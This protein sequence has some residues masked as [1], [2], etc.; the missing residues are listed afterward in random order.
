LDT[1]FADHPL[2]EDR[3]AATEAQ[4]AKINPAIIRTLTTDT[5]AF[6]DFKARVHSLPAPPVQRSR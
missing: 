3:I 4:I 1:W 6:D 5:R 2:E